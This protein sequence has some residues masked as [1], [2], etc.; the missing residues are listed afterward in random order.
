MTNQ[1]TTIHRHPGFAPVSI[2]TLCMSIGGGSANAS[3][4]LPDFSSAIFTPG[5]AINNPY[6][7]L[8]PTYRTTLRAEGVDDEG[9]PFFEESRLRYGGSGKVILGVQTTVQNDLAFED[10]VLVEETKDYYAQDTAANVWYMGEDVTN[11]VY[12]EDGNLTGTN[13]SSS[14]IAGLNG[15]LPGYIMPFDPTVGLSYFQEY[16]AI[17]MAL[18][19]ALIVGAGLTLEVNGTI[20]ND[21]LAIFETTS[22]DPNARELKYYAPYVGI[23]RAEE[24]VDMGLMNSVL[25]ADRVTPSPVPL[26]AGFPLLL[27]GLGGLVALRSRRTPSA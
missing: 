26:P 6:F 4:L 20:F 3:T 15:A 10:G 22:L 23:I 27:V 17:D 25:T 11:Y 2:L 24:G 16:A 19:Q 21:V 18:D 1:A 7:P 14:W 12:D 8:G 9:Q 13:N 5:A